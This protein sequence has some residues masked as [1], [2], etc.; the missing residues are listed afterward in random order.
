MSPI[1]PAA[2]WKNRAKEVN[3]KLAKDIMGTSIYDSYNNSFRSS[4]IKRNMEAFFSD[5]GAFEQMYGAI[6]STYFNLTGMG[7]VN[8]DF[9]S[10]RIASHR[11]ASHRIAG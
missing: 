11:I 9:A 1:S 6:K 10:H 3:D 2:D 5:G 7:K 8:Y 4:A